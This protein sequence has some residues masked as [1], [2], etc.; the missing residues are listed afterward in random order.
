MTG[1]AKTMSPRA[2]ADALVEAL[3]GLSSAPEWTLLTQVRSHAAPYEVL[4]IADAIAVRTT[5]APEA[6]IEIHGFEAKRS[7][8]DWL[9]ELSTP[10]KS[11]PFVVP[12][13]WKR[14]VLALSEL[15]DGWGLEHEPEG[16]PSPRGG[17][18]DGFG[19]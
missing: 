3:S 14:V 12:A 13:P 10:E 9:R 4:R 19:G 5:G 2:H 6:P 16:S 18:R 11:G 15:P 7:R 1:R 17:F 8:S